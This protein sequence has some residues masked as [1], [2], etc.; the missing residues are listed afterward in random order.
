MIWPE[1]QKAAALDEIERRLC[2]G[3]WLV[4]LCR[5]V[6]LP[7]RGLLRT[8]MDADEAV[9]ARI[10]AAMEDGYD[11][12]ALETIN[13]ADSLDE[14]PASRTVRIKARMVLLE[15]LTRRYAAKVE[16][17]GANGAE[18]FPSKVEFTF[19]EAPARDEQ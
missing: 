4:N 14:H 7:P 18:L 17:T 12:V 2:A 8:W 1:E 10:N 9:A 3:E 5:E 6:H 15:K 13:I 11:V 19:V 16:H